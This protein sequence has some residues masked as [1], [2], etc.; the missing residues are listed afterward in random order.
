MAISLAQTLQQLFI[1]ATGKAAN[2]ANLAW[3][4]STLGSGA[5]FSQI[6][7]TINQYMSTQARSVGVIGMIQ[8]IARNGLGRELT[9]SEAEGAVRDL[10]AV[11]IDSW[12]KL[13]HWLVANE[14]SLT[15]P[16]DNRAEA[17]AYFKTQ[18]AEK[19][20]G[21]LF[22]GAS[23]TSAVG[24]LLQGIGASLQS[25][26]NSRQ[27]LAQL[28]ANLGPDGITSSVVDGYIA[29]ASVF[30]DANGDGLLNFTDTDNDGGWDAGEGEW[31]G[32]TDANGNYVLPTNAPAGVINASG[33]I[34]ILTNK[35]F[36]GVLTAPAGSTVVNPLTT[37]VQGLIESGSSVA[38]ACAIIQQGLD[39]PVDINLLS[40]NPLL[41]LASSTASAEDKAIALAVQTIALQIMNVI[42]QVGNAI[43]TTTGISVQDAGKDVAAAL[44]NNIKTAVATGGSEATVDLTDAAVITE[45][46][47][48]SAPGALITSVINNVTSIVVA[49]NNSA[50]EATNITELSKAAVVSQGDA[51]NAII[52]GITNNTLGTAVTNFTGTNLDTK[53]DVAVPGV[54]TNEP[55]PDPT[56]IF[57][58]TE[59]PAGTWTVSTDNG[60]VVITDTG[61]NY[62]F[63]PTT[64]TAVSVLKTAVT[65]SLVVGSITLSGAAV[66]VK[67]LPAITGSV[68]VSDAGT[69]TA[70]DLNTIDTLTSGL[71][72]AT[73]ATTISGTAAAI[74]T[75]IVTNQGTSGNKIQ[76]SAD[77]SATVTDVGSIA[78]TALNAVDTATTGIVVASGITAITGTAAQNKA[79][80]DALGTTGNK[81]S[82][83]T[84]TGSITDA[85]I[86]ITDSSVTLAN[87][88]S[89]EAAT[90]GL[91]TATAVT[92]TSGTASD[93]TLLLVT[94]EGLSGNK[95]DMKADVAVTLSDSGSIA[96]TA[97][98]SVNGG[99][100]GL[101]TAASITTV[102]GSSSEIKALV[103]ALGTSG[104]K[105]SVGTMTGSVTNAALTA[106]SGSSNASDV[107]AILA[108]SSGAVT[109]R[110]VNT[111][112][113][114]SSFTV[115]SGDI[116]NIDPFNVTTAL[117][118]TA[119]ADVGSVDTSGEW[120]FDTTSKL[121]TWFDDD[122]PAVNS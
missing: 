65:T 85:A 97:L 95:I 46:V 31:N 82:L 110:L 64:G 81:I 50:A 79:V 98:S 39:L 73:A 2:N 12:A 47:Q 121:F 90:S 28:A 20:N 34:D 3:L 35:P 49:S 117:D 84:M 51:T 15:T 63:T 4:E 91:V 32:T 80:T 94:N 41:D 5:N 107:S 54:L 116:I 120:F 74:T 108:A 119:Q 76:T 1:L 75:T 14:T 45:V 83:G 42:T 72:I 93:A 27:G 105:L 103:D 21:H 109:V 7:Q 87:L 44:A 68:T 40:Y 113:T 69:V 77:L 55:A 114:G 88:K 25:V 122:E 9:V 43:A 118:A 58:V 70:A 96:A 59:S 36:L 29:G 8:A 106:T 101:V 112:I 100:T 16:L 56:A 33:G 89:I 67:S 22:D 52:S 10:K 48:S 18:L 60:N 23:L 92:A 99:T 111:Y 86:T 13:L 71:V 66:V 30:A 19:G 53:V 102:T 6:D 38:Q 61:T 104:D 78:A 37:L 26:E 62:L 57:G 24:N 115:A 11:G 17:V